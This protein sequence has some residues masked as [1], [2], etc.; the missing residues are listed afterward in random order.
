MG[1][2]GDIFD[3]N[4]DGE[5]DAFEKG[6]EFGAFMNMVDSCKKDELESAGIDLADF[7]FMDEDERNEALEEAGLDPDDFDF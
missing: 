3:F 6:A 4:N 2:F 1:I 7:E 5:M